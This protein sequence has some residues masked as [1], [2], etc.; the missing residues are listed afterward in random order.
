MNSIVGILTWPFRILLWV[1]LWIA[2]K[3][4]LGQEKDAWILFAY[5]L[6]LA[7]GSIFFYRW[8]HAFLVFIFGTDM[9]LGTEL[10]P[11]PPA[12][13]I[14]PIFFLPTAVVAARLASLVDEELFYPYW[15]QPFPALNCSLK[16]LAKELPDPDFYF[17]NF[18]VRE[19]ALFLNVICT[20]GIGSGKCLGPDTRIKLADGTSREARD[21][22]PGD[23]IMGADQKAQKVLKTNTGKGTMFKISPKEKTRTPWTCNDR[24][25]MVLKYV[26]PKTGPEAVIARA[27]VGLDPDAVL[28]DGATVE[29]ELEKFLNASGSLRGFAISRFWKLTDQDGNVHGWKA[30]KL[31]EGIFYGFTLNGNGRFLLE[32]GTI[33]HN[34]AAFVYP[35]MDQLFREYNV[36]RGG[37]RENCGGLLLDVKGEFIDAVITLMKRH[38]RDPEKDLIVINPDDPYTY[39]YNPISPHMNHLQVANRLRSILNNLGGGGGDSFWL[40]SAEK[41]VA[42]AILIIRITHGQDRANLG[43]VNRIVA[44]KEYLKGQIIKAR[45]IGSKLKPPDPQTASR[46]EK[47]EF[48]DQI[49]NIRAVTAFFEKEWMDMAE[50]TKSGIVAAISNQLLRGFTDPKLQRVFCQNTEFS[51]FDT[52]NQGKIVVLQ[53]P[54]WGMT[55]LMIGAALKLD[56]Q[57]C[58]KDRI[59]KPGCNKTR[60]VFFIADEYQ[61][62]VTCGGKGEGDEG[63][64]AVSRQ[65]KIINA[66]ATQSYNSL[67]AKIK[68]PDAVDVLLQN[69]RIKICLNGECQKTAQKVSALIGK[70]EMERMS[71]YTKNESGSM[72]RLSKHKTWTNELKAEIEEWDFYK[73]LTHIETKY[74]GQ[75]NGFEKNMAASYSEAIIFNAGFG[76]GDPVYSKIRLKPLWIPDGE[77]TKNKEYW[78]KNR[79]RVAELEREDREKNAVHAA[80][81]T[82]IKPANEVAGVPLPPPATSSGKTNSQTRPQP[83]ELPDPPD[84]AAGD[85]PD[86]FGG[87]PTGRPSESGGTAATAPKRKS[88]LERVETEME[89]APRQ[90][91]QGS[92]GGAYAPPQG[93]SDPKD[94]E[95]DVAEMEQTDYAT[96]SPDDDQQETLLTQAKFANRAFEEI[97]ETE[98]LEENNDFFAELILPTNYPA[99]TLEHT[100]SEASRHEIDAIDTQMEDASEEE[101]SQRSARARIITKTVEQENEEDRIAAAAIRHQQKIKEENEKNKGQ[102]QPSEKGETPVEKDPSQR[103]DL[104]PSQKIPPHPGAKRAIN[105]LADSPTLANPAEMSE[106]SLRQNKAIRS[107]QEVSEEEE[108]QIPRHK[109]PPRPIDTMPE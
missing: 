87:L 29:I 25:I 39:C 100:N 66:V 68:D 43:L 24:H 72:L 63:F 33:T 99:G 37:N 88:L 2:R 53:A 79:S 103:T 106:E 22:R 59:I 12:Y 81:G 54:G 61:E 28:E 75:K 17:G 97:N 67:Y 32:D 65:S 107:M 69:M 30:E 49:K 8:F 64:Y 80:K 36:N 96:A 14:A 11:I 20:G 31:G 40:D 73:L 38:G 93:F 109:L 13:L 27:Q 3:T 23:M 46:L 48:E 51:M 52:V 104:L 4:P 41:V 57:Q 15:D 98:G 19:N 76:R 74:R 102:W 5:F 92:D 82:L 21:I 56:F 55:A 85:F 71:S 1:A 10:L 9:Y 108:S 77:K 18:R 42:N 105:L 45:T 26:E 62:Y 83:A 34:T 58:M 89:N 44:D 7:G 95:M 6:I 94:Y 60:R 84:D 101:L 86:D 16:L 91:P 90:T 50:A 35:F 78:T 47:Q 70:I